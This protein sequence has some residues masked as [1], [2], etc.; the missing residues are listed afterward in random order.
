MMKQI[1]LKYSCIPVKSQWLSGALMSQED[2][3]YVKKK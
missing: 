2:I 3:I 1:K